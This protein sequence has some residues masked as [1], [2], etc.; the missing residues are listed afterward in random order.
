M[1]I[2]SLSS[3]MKQQNFGMFK[4]KK[5]EKNYIQL[6]GQAIQTEK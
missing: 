3:T 1:D 4:I 5:M 2:E 6:Y